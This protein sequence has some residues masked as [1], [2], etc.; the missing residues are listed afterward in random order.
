MSEED[1]HKY[2]QISLKFIELNKSN[3]INIYLKHLNGTEENEGAIT[4]DKDEVEEVVNEA[5]TVIGTSVDGAE[6][7]AYHFGE[8]E[9]EVGVDKKDGRVLVKINPKYYRPA[10]VEL[11]LGDASKAKNVLGWESKTS[12]D[13]LVKIMVDYDLEHNEYGFD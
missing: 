11:L 7:T 4:Y 5:E 1:I 2:R 3:L 10:E 6:I 8:G 12:L 9:K 13:E